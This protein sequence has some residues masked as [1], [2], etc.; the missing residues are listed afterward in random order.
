MES[1]VVNDYP[2]A[3]IIKQVEKDNP[4]IRCEDCHELLSI[5]FNLNKKE[6][7]L[8][9]E[10]E[11]KTKNIP[12]ETFFESIDKYKELNCC[13]L[14]KI[15]ILLKFIICVKHARIKFYAKIV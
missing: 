11:K 9:C 1:Q 12:F 10:K 6:I 5:N 13:E 8:I 14:C 4:I 3:N 7:Q 2:P 15:K